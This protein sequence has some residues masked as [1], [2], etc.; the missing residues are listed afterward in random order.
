MLEK[1][2]HVSLE[3]LL[4]D[5]VGRLRFGETALA[6]YRRY[7]QSRPWH[8]E[9]GGQLFATI[10]DTLI[11]VVE[12]TGPRPGDRRSFFGFEPNRVAEQ[13]EIAER[14]AHGL[15]FVG[16]WHSHRQREPYPSTT[17]LESMGDT[18]RNSEHSLK[19]FV[20]VVVGTAKPPDGLHV[21]FHTRSGWQQLVL[22]S[23][24]NEGTT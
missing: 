21:S 13:W 3:Y 8:R 17:D 19:G 7:R 11:D 20:L 6:Q 12:A 1:M 9:A 15:H 18:V 24:E 14:Y 23:W 5:G 10:T 22:A 4:P 16:D 2:K